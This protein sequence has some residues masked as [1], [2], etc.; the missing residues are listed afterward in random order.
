MLEIDLLR[1]YYLKDVCPAGWFLGVWVSKRHQDTLLAKT[2]VR[3][4]F[5]LVDLLGWFSFR[6]LIKRLETGQLNLRVL[7]ETKGNNEN[8]TCDR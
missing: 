2:L 4:V 5:S 8:M 6:A 1:N 3:D 7:K